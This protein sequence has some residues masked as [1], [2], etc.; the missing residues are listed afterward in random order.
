MPI[1][2]L[3]TQKSTTNSLGRIEIKIYKGGRKSPKAAGKDLN[4]KLRITTSNPTARVV[5]TEVYGKPIEVTETVGNPPKELKEWDFVVDN[6]EFYLPYSKPEK[7]CD[8]QMRKY[9]KNGLEIVCDRETISFK[10]SETTDSKGNVFCT[11][12]TEPE[13]C[14]VRGQSFAV[15]CPYGCNKQGTLF[16]YIKALADRDL[17]LPAQLVFTGFTDITY[18]AQ[19]LNAIASLVGNLS[20]A[21]FFCPVYRHHVPYSL[22]RQTVK[23][24]RSIHEKRSDASASET[25][26]KYRRTGAKMKS[27]TWALSISV[28]PKY[29][30]LRDV[31][32]RMEAATKWG[33]QPDP[34]VIRGFLAQQGVEVIDIDAEVVQPQAQLTGSVDVEAVRQQLTN[35]S[36]ELMKTLEWTSDMGREYLEK[37]FGVR[38]RQLLTTE[39][40]QDF[41]WHL[42][43]I[44][45]TE[46]VW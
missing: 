4:E 10:N 27:T 12:S 31:A 41:V 37:K 22:Q 42:K 39:Q 6:I 15:K 5:L 38:S 32:M 7:N 16:L 17:W 23:L 40:L 46:E 44:P 11:P 35:E 2:G 8:P 19:E 43:S 20:Q 45:K 1:A 18:V 24:N 26:E 25:G 9:G 14:P 13:P 29:L 28:L 33:L 30:E 21:D 36:S 34:S 3:T